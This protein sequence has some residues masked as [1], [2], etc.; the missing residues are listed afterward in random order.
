[1]I[2]CF[3][4]S[5]GRASFSI[6]YVIGGLGA[7]GPLRRSVS[8]TSTVGM[9]SSSESSRRNAA[10]ATFVTVT[11]CQLTGISAST[12]T[13]KRFVRNSPTSR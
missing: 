2:N 5:T 13:R 6:V 8:G 7:A 12:S 3:S 9:S 4:T 11:Q 1:M 10:R